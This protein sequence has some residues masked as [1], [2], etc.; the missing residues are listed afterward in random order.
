MKRITLLAC[1]IGWTGFV[2]AQ[3][4][5]APKPPPPASIEAP[6]TDGGFTAEAAAA[7]V[8]PGPRQ[9]V[10]LV[11]EWPQWMGPRGDGASEPG[12]LPFGVTVT[13]E[14]D[15]RQHVGRGYSSISISGS[16][17]LTLEADGE[18]VW[19]VALDIAD[20][21]EQW[22]VKLENPPRSERLEPPLSTPATDGE[23]V[24][25]THPAG[26]LFA[27]RAADGASVWSRDLVRDFGASPPSYGMSTS[28]VLLG[29]RLA[30]LAG[31]RGGHNLLVFDPASGEL[32]FSQGPERQGSYSTP[33]AGVLAGE[34]QLIVPGSE[35]LY[36]LRLAGGAPA[37]KQEAWALE[38]IPYPDR[39]PLVLSESRVFLAFEEHAAMFEVSAESGTARELW[40]SE[41]LSN[42]YSPA[43][44]HGG[45]IYGIGR[46][47]ILCLDA[48][49]GRTL[50]QEPA[51]IGTLIRV[52]DHLVHFGT[53][54]GW[55]RLV[56]ASP[57]GFHEAAALPVFP[58][59][60]H[61][62]TAPSFGAGR[63][64]VRGRNEIAAVRLS[65]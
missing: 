53:Q 16:R 8:P 56:A 35:R 17:A 36:G 23:R 62:V 13:L 22:R 64:F 49:T 21:Q 43:V 33:V 57:E 34:A 50:W 19:A 32:L 11:G 2:A 25:A 51:G 18:A 58:R 7:V 29:D 5:E 48:A 46:D 26:L 41:Q 39:S 24:Y 9:P 40:R 15:W 60:K 4:D 14:I 12:W 61:G 1:M 31:G 3:E 42:S 65:F 6:W 28:P 30:V 45:S 47:R 20:G 44:A 27:L 59:G 55:L 63:I 38:G 54:S 10:P 37:D 52:D